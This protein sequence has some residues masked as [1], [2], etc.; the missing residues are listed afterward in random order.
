M[1]ITVAGKTFELTDCQN[2]DYRH[3]N[4]RG[5]PYC[6]IKG[7]VKAEKTEKRPEGCRCSR[8]AQAVPEKDLAIRKIDLA[9]KFAASAS[10]NLCTNEIAAARME[11]RNACVAIESAL[12][13]I[14]KMEM[15]GGAK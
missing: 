10:R 11:A 1:K 6:R 5:H 8:F 14:E 12:E 4:L 13:L 3:C 2:L 7:Y 15:E 9:Y